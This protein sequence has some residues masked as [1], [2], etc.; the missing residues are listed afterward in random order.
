MIPFRFYEVSQW[1]I[2]S[3]DHFFGWAVGKGFV[4]FGLVFLRLR[5]QNRDLN[6]DLAYFDRCVFF[7]CHDLRC[8]YLVW[9]K[10]GRWGRCWWFFDLYVIWLL[11]LFAAD[12]IQ[13]RQV[14][15]VGVFLAWG[16]G[17]WLWFLRVRVV[18]LLLWGELRLLT[19]ISTSSLFWVLCWWHIEL[20]YIIYNLNSVN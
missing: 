13:K 14:E 9:N 8:W 15:R 4:F 12:A 5:E 6:L 10:L 7:G 11:C 3:V 2:L 1:A 18:Y 16:L 20:I 19:R 17:Y